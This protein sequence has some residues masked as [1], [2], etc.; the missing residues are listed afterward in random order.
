MLRLPVPHHRS[1]QMLVLCKRRQD[2]LTKY[3]PQVQAYK[4]GKKGVLG[5]FVGEVMKLTKGKA[6]A[7]KL[8]ELILERLEA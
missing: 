5:L 6:D 2:T 7:K 1:M 4:T 3:Q 8:N